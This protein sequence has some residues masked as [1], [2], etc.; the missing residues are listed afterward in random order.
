MLEDG[1]EL[2]GIVESIL[3]F[4]KLASF[5]TLDLR[6]ISLLEMTRALYAIAC[7][8]RVFGPLS[9]P[10]RSRWLPA[11]VIIGGSTIL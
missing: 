5:V 11:N 7:L 3:E 4:Y 6:G 2:S 9:V 1:T 8:Q 10:V